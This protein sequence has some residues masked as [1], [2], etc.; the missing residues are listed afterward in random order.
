MVVITAK[1]ETAI[2]QEIID[3]IKSF[4]GDAYHVHGGSV[5]RSG[6]PDVTGEIHV[7]TS[8]QTYK[9]VHVKLEIKTLTGKPSQ[10]QMLRLNRYIH[11][12]YMAGIVT[13]AV[14]LYDL[15]DEFI[16]NGDNT[17]SWETTCAYYNYIPL[18]APTANGGLRPR[19]T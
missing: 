14:D 1:A 2:T 16:V 5:Q 6:E 7:Q 17:A 13:H 19:Q 8:N 15:L 3:I 10:L 9:W 4:G 18:E 12:G 11:S